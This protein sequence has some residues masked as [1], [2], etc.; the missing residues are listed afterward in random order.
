MKHWWTLLQ[1]PIMSNPTYNRIA[2][3]VN[4]NISIL[5]TSQRLALL[6]IY[7]PQQPSSWLQFKTVRWISMPK[8][9][10]CPSS[11]FILNLEQCMSLTLLVYSQ[12]LL[13]WKLVIVIFLGQFQITV[14][15]WSLPHSQEI[16]SYSLKLVIKY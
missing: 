12:W 7:S 16:V 10:V 2:F 1:G 13:G 9:I 8:F 6:L 11:T 4:F 3:L 5:C 15:I 14:V